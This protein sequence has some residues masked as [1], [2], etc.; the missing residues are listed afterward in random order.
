MSQLQEFEDTP[1]P[2]WAEYSVYQPLVAVNLTA[3][4]NQG[5]IQ[6]VP[7]LAQSWNVSSNGST[8]TFNLRS[9]VTFSNGDAFNAYQ[10]WAMMYGDYYLSANSS[11][12]MEGYTIFNMTSVDFGPATLVLL[13]QPGNLASPSPQ[14]LAVM[15]NASW[16]IYVTG[17]DTIVFQLI[18]PFQWFL[19]LVV[20]QAGL[21]YDVNYVLQNGGYGT[22]DSV[23]L[24]FN[25]SPIPGT[26]PYVFTSVSENAYAEFAQNTHYWGDSLSASAVASNPALDPGHV[27]NIIIQYKADDVVRYSDLSTGAAQ[28]AAIETSDWNLITASPNQFGY[29]VLPS[30][31]GLLAAL[32]LNTQLYPT[33]NTDF[34]LAI[35]HA[36]NY[37][38]IYQQVFVGEMSPWVGPEYPAW[39]NF[40][41]LGGAQPYQYN[42]T[43][44]EQ[45]LNESHID[46]STVTLT[47]PVENTCAFC[48]T[49]AELI[50]NDLGAIGISVDI[51]I[52]SSSSWCNNLCGSYSTNLAD[53]SNLGNLNDV[54][55]SVYAPGALTPADTWMS[56]VSNES[57]TGNQ[58]IYYNP[59]VQSCV[60]AFTT[61]SSASEIQSLCIAAQAQIQS[62]AP[63]VWLGVAKLWYG[64]GS[65]AW[66]KS[67]V[68]GFYSDPTWTGYD[69]EPIL[70]TI[71]LASGS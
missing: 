40:Y 32:S 24:A 60:D 43:L 18:A 27:K 6:Y 13:S 19:G 68:S 51:E 48:V 37:T 1:W 7:G 5:V 54:Y 11:N 38:Q 17:P 22:P 8:Y 30:E 59:T 25:T 21:V 29:T 10:V 57:V 50:Q 15:D 39:S 61:A 12:W 42:V 44:A 33:N 23:S 71:T 58:A 66:S 64:G 46:P 9:G 52:M 49:R 4:Y 53:P 26:G 16:P 47:Y 36:I 55:G 69:T 70:N 65:E 14:A 63:Y 41:D 45:Y 31:S 35:A 34:R 2:D 20:T 3:E 62:D 67:V 28:I 56:L